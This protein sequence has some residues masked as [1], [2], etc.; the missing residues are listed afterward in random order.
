MAG[1][2]VQGLV[3]KI[4]IVVKKRLESTNANSMKTESTRF[5]AMTMPTIRLLEWLL[6]LL[7]V[8]LLVV[9]ANGLPCICVYL[10]LG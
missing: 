2:F 5:E 1:G 8:V 3:P 9:V 4:V 7:Q 6:L 10:C